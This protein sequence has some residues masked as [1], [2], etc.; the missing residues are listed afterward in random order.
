MHYL[1]SSVQTGRGDLSRFRR[2]VGTSNHGLAIR[3]AINVNCRKQALSL[4][5]NLPI[6]GSMSAM[7]ML[8]HLIKSSRESTEEFFLSENANGG[9]RQVS[10]GEIAFTSARDEEQPRR[11]DHQVHHQTENRSQQAQSVEFNLRQ[12]AATDKDHIL[13]AALR[14]DR[15]KVAAGK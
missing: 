14:G 13:A 12:V 9:N 5:E 15:R 10:V 6:L 4:I 3:R 2:G 7:G 8:Q 11:S 1:L